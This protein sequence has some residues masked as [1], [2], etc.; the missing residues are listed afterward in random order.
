MNGTIELLPGPEL[1]HLQ[2]MYLGR[3]SGDIALY[4]VIFCMSNLLSRIRN[5]V[6]THFVEDLCEAPGRPLLKV[7]VTQFNKPRPT[8]ARSDI[9]V[10]CN[11]ATVAGTTFCGTPIFLVENFQGSSQ[12][13]ACG[14]RLSATVGGVIKVT[15][16]NRNS[17]LYGMTAGQIFEEWQGAWDEANKGASSGAVVD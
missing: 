12:G 7:L 1:L 13:S 9:D 17:K 11:P 16:K 3:D 5:L 14:E 10:Y 6:H 8:F 4:V 2:C 15:I